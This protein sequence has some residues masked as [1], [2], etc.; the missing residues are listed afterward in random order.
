MI[1]FLMY[2]NLFDLLVKLNFFSV[3]HFNLIPFVIILGF[4]LGLAISKISSEV[5]KKIWLILI[6]LTSIMVVFNITRIVPIEMQ[7]ASNKKG[8]NGPVTSVPVKKNEGATPDI[9]WLIFDEF[10]GFDVMRD[11]F[12][13]PE[14]DAFKT[15]LE[16]LGLVVIEDSHSSSSKTLHQ[17][18]TRLNYQA[19]DK[20]LSEVDLYPY[21]TR[22]RVFD[23][24]KL[25]GYTTVVL[26]EARSSRI[27][28]ASKPQIDAD[29][30]LEEFIDNHDVKSSKLFG[31]FSLL[32][33]K[34]TM[35]R[36]ITHLFSIDDEEIAIHRNHIY[37]V[38]DQ[39]G[40]LDIPSPKF[41]YSHL[42]LPHKPFMF[43]Q[44]GTLLEPSQYQN[45]QNYLGQYIFTLKII[46]D[47]IKSIQS[48]SD[49]ENPPVIILQSDH[50]ARNLKEGGKGGEGP[51]INYP[52]KHHTS[53]LYAVYAPM[54]PDMPLKDGIDPINTFPVIFNCLFDMDIPLQ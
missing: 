11:Y 33:A 46:K 29:I 10:A 51:L 25:R 49:P 12:N 15:D 4:Y 52:D 13:Y 30:H 54:C 32:I 19:F 37:L 23:V 31:E 36:T 44:Y 14:I 43:S 17:I 16:T 41:V 22:S 35:F 53:I 45:Y 1:L 9:Y 38:S 21:I 18:A 50:G 48:S 42:L 6:A 7:K 2:G 40:K 8:A 26:D 24:L 34:Q 27:G 20:D 47:S 28:F 3:R 39:L 5:S